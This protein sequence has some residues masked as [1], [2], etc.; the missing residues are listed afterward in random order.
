MLTVLRC[1]Y[2]LN[3]KNITL[4]YFTKFLMQNF[5]FQY[6]HGYAT[7]HTRI[8]ERGCRCGCKILE[9][10]WNRLEICDSIPEFIMQTTSSSESDGIF[11]HKAKFQLLPST[12]RP[13]MACTT[14]RIDVILIMGLGYVTRNIYW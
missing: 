13:A 10:L 3:R 6:C 11:S 2:L 8:Y 9:R 7:S 1:K 5:L 4:H 14:R 12:F